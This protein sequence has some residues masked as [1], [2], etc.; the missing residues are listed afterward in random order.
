MV[1]EYK[2]QF[3][4]KSKELKSKVATLLNLTLNEIIQLL[5]YQEILKIFG[6]A[7]I[8]WPFG[9]IAQSTVGPYNQ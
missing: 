3:K 6:H 8:P 4:E 9:D 1:S 2:N 7:L 5:F